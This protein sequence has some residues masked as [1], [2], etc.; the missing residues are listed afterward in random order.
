MKIPLLKSLVIPNFANYPA[1]FNV[2]TT[3]QQNSI[4]KF[5]FILGTIQL[6]L[7]CLMNIRKKL[8]QKDLSWLSDL[9]WLC[10]I[11]ALYFVVLY[12]V[13]R[14]ADQPDPRGGGC[15][16]RFLLVVCF[17]GMSPDKTFAQGLKAGLGD[18]FTVFLNTISAFGNIMSYIR[19]FAVGMASLAIAQ[20]FNNMAAGFSGPLIIVGAL[21]MIIGHGLNVVMG[22]L[23][24]VVHGVRLNLLEF[25]GQ[26]GMEWAG[27]A[28]DPFRKFDKIK[29]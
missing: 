20:S 25:S 19:L 22:L 13:M 23:S 26:L 29:K 3:Q 27:I 8:G 9:G 6:S 15:G 1:Y 11:C 12:L 2:S 18:A 28:Y 14:S 4:M 5:C 24:V 17:G 7:A 21:I 16:H 10:S